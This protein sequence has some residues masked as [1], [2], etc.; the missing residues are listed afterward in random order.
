MINN[1]NNNWQKEFKVLEGKHKKLQLYM[2]RMLEEKKKYVATI[3]AKDEELE[4]LKCIVNE[5][6]DFQEIIK[7]FE[8]ERVASQQCIK[9]KDEEIDKLKSQVNSYP[10]LNDPQEF[11]LASFLK[12]FQ[13]ATH[14]LD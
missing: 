4:G 5:Q 9:A 10:R 6:S 7:S 8:E 1:D 13:A 3:K 2:R 11:N 12:L 14:S